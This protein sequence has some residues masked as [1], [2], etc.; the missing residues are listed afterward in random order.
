MET[1][2][3]LNCYILNMTITNDITSTATATERKI[4]LMCMRVTE[5]ENLDLL[6]CIPKMIGRPG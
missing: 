4:D 1:L 2:C 3:M 5:K 6:K